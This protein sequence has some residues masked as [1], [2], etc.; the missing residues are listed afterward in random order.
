MAQQCLFGLACIASTRGVDLEMRVCVDCRL[1]FHHLCASKRSD[2]MSRCG[3]CQTIQSSPGYLSPNPSRQFDTVNTPQSRFE[4][5]WQLSVS[6]VSTPIPPPT[7]SFTPTVSSTY[8]LLFFPIFL[9]NFAGT[10][11]RHDVN[12]GAVHVNKEAMARSSR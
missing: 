10:C 6:S 12:L 8:S 9:Y 7:Q 5:D 2:D 11:V 4:S 3:C 1:P